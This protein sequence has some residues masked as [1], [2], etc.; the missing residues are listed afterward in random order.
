MAICNYCESEMLSTHGCADVPIVMV[1]G[2]TYAPVRYG[3]EIGWRHPKGSCGDC[4][5][6]PGN[7]HHHGCDL[8]RCPRCLQQ[9]ITCGCLWAG[10]EHLEED[11]EHLEEDWDEEWEARLFP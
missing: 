7:V 3:D 9:A 1:D 10:E 2:T 5:V 11:E 8:E 4:G 6:L